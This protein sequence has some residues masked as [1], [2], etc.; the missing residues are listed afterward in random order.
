M[1]HLASYKVEFMKSTQRFLFQVHVSESTAVADHCS[2]YALSDVTNSQLQTPCQ[3]A[4][5]QSFSQCEDLRSVLQNIEKHLL[6]EA[7]MPEEELEELE[8]LSVVA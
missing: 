1:L 4:H 6:N 7:R 8:H 5:G 3:H 2:T